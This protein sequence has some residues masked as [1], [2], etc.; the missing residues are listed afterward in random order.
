MRWKFP[1]ERMRQWGTR[2][3]TWSRLF[4]KIKTQT[5]YHGSATLRILYSKFEQLI[6]IDPVGLDFSII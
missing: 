2:Y 4:Y 1:D 3:L 5:C 6:F